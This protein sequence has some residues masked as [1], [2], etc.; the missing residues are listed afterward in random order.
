LLPEAPNKPTRRATSGFL[1]DLSLTNNIASRP[2]GRVNVQDYEE[3]AC[4]MH[5]PTTDAYIK[6][7]YS[8]R[9]RFNIYTKVAGIDSI[10]INPRLLE[11]D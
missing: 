4:N 5:P 11:R 2:E 3:L 9:W 6:K 10:A 8:S 7:D 1:E